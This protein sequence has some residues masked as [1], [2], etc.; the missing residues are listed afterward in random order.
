MAVDRWKG[1]SEGRTRAQ[2]LVSEMSEQIRRDVQWILLEPGLAINFGIIQQYS[3]MLRS[4]ERFAEVVSE[5]NPGY[6]R[7]DLPKGVQ[8]DLNIAHHAL[9]ILLGLYGPREA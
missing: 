8:D 3:E 9:N 4:L 1:F 7:K 6:W 5:S 2:A